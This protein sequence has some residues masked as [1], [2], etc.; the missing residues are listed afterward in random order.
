M[1]NVGLA[2]GTST[3]RDISIVSGSNICKALREKDHNA[4]LVDIFCGLEDVNWED[5]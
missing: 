4:I 5:T 1:Q 3:E 2:G